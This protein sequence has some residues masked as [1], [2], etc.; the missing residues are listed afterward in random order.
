MKN[1]I[2]IL[3]F[4]TPALIA[5]NLSISQFINLRTKGFAEIEEV[6]TEKNWTYVKGSEATNSVYGSALFAL[7]KNLMS[8]KAESF[9]QYIYSNDKSVIRFRIQISNNELY[10][11]YIK[12]I[13]N[14]GC[15]LIK[16]NIEEHRIIKHYQ[17]K[18]TTIII[19]N[20]SEKSDLGFTETKYIFL[21]LSNEDYKDYKEYF[22]E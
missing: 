21:I 6:L 12:Q 13:K 8:D 18:T 17:G 2:L 5:Q 9:A 16:T 15:K 4:Y 20:Q 10:S 22:G 1:L 14:L 3:F 7:N 11:D 19:K